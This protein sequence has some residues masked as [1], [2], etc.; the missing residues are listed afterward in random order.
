MFI[1][2]SLLLLKERIKKREDVVVGV[3]D[4]WMPLVIGKVFPKD[5]LGENC[6]GQPVC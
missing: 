6:V 1:R 4:I 5:K 2:A 3:V